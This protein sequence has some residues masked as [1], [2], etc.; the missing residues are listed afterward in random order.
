MKEKESRSFLIRVSRIQF[1]YAVKRS[2]QYRLIIRHLFMGR[3]RVIP[4]QRE[5]ELPVLIG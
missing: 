5:R 1:L 3:V 2:V 4:Q